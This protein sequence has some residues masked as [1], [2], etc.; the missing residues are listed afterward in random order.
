MRWAIHALV[1][2]ID[3]SAYARQKAHHGGMKKSE[4]SDVA[5]RSVGQ[6]PFPNLAAASHVNLGWSWELAGSLDEI[7]GPHGS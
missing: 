6:L 5:G 2:L 7:L 4:Q 1:Y 3:C